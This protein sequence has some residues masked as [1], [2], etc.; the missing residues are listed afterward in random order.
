MFLLCS[1]HHKF[2]PISFKFKM[3]THTV[4]TRHMLL[5]SKWILRPPASLSYTMPSLLFLRHMI[6][7][8]PLSTR[9]AAPLSPVQCSHLT[10][11]HL[12]SLCSDF[13]ALESTLNLFF[14][15]NKAALHPNLLPS[16]FLLLYF[17]FFF[18]F[19]FSITPALFS[20]IHDYSFY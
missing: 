11:S 6:Q 15:L 13:A 20:Y 17:S 3:K 8:C 1:K 10:H 5:V 7:C 9:T 16:Q 14:F 4:A 2:A 19:I 12:S 18:P